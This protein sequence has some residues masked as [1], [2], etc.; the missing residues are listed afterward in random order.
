MN[1][2]TKAMRL[3]EWLHAQPWFD[4]WFDI[5]CHTFGQPE[6]YGIVHQFVCGEFGTRTLFQSFEWRETPQGFNVWAERDAQMQSYIMT[7]NA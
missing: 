1:G 3:V 6:D 7:L 5:L 2:D 4:E